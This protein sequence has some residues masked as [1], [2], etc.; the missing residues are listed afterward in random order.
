ML[1]GNGYAYPPSVLQRGSKPLLDAFPGATMAFSLRKLRTT[2]TGPCVKVRNDANQLATIN[3]AGSG[4][5]TTALLAHAG[6]G[7]CYVET[8][9]NQASGAIVFDLIQP[10]N[11]NQPV[12]VS[13]GA[14]IP[15]ATNRNG[16]RFIDTGSST[17]SSQFRHSPTLFSSTS[18]DPFTPN[19]ANVFISAKPASSN[20]SSMLQGANG[21]NRINPAD[22][23]L[24]V[25]IGGDSYSFSD[26][27]SGNDS[28]YTIRYAQNNLT[29][30]A[31][32][33]KAI[34][35]PSRGHATAQISNQTTNP[36][37]QALR[38]AGTT[39]R[40]N[41]VIGEII[42]YPN[43]NRTGYT[44]PISTSVMATIQDNIV[45]YF[46]FPSGSMV[47]PL[48]IQYGTRVNA[49]GAATAE[50]AAEYQ[51]CLNLRFDTLYNQ[52]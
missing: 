1:I 36:F 12:I 3:F 37:G 52:I 27:N 20:S 15:F 32:R 17:T 2:Y 23:Q 10:T 5:D 8:W 44:F 11:A 26:N 45:G 29:I 9:Y 28:L 35:Q 42:N 50:T 43:Y 48:W 25:Q 24:T 31:Y 46:K 14:M 21:A 41:G 51:G 49:N 34:L 40:Y 16:I 39:A 18:V 33:N 4:V 47:I 22:L 30:F 7:N 19:F 13:G 6:T 38:I